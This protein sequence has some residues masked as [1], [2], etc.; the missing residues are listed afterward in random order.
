MAHASA[1]PFVGPGLAPAL[2]ERCAQLSKTKC[3]RT[4]DEI[5]VHA[6]RESL[7]HLVEGHE[8]SPVG[9]EDAF[10]LGCCPEMQRDYNIKQAGR[11][12]SGKLLILPLT[13]RRLHLS[14]PL[15]R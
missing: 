15:G 10:P 14:V 13:P 6:I 1:S 8:L 3:D 9:P 5:E 4:L 2:Q 7:A 11:G 12:R